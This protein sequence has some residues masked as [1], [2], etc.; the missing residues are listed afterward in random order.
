MIELATIDDI[1][2]HAP[3]PGQFGSAMKPYY[4]AGRHKG[5][6]VYH[7]GW[8]E[9]DYSENSSGESIYAEEKVKCFAKYGGFADPVTL[10]TVSRATATYHRIVAPIARVFWGTKLLFHWMVFVGRSRIVRLNALM[11]RVR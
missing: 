10:R 8:D 9:Q 1:Y 3:L 6:E 5:V 2:P 7:L 11:G 4:Y